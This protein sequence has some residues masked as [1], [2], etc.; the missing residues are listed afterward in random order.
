M[1]FEVI[2]P[3]KQPKMGTDYFD[4]VPWDDISNMAQAGYT[5]KWEGQSISKTLLLKRITEGSRYFE[6]KPVSGVL[7]VE[8]GKVYNKQSEAAKDL[9]IDPAQ[10]SDSIKTGRPRSGY[11]FKKV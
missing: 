1:L 2:G 3:D 7:C 9:G 10:V 6:S 11:T 8:T 4:L 5:F